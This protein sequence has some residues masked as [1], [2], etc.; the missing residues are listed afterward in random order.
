ME[1]YSWL[2]SKEILTGR[3]SDTVKSYSIHPLLNKSSNTSDFLNNR[4]EE[5][6]FY[7]SIVPLATL[8]P[9]SV[10]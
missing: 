8:N 5:I 2:T 3:W 4:T 6:F 1:D 7:I 9:P 10:R